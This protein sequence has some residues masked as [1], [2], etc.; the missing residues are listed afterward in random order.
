MKRY[1]FTLDLIDDNELITAYKQYHERI[2]PEISASIKS[3]GILD[4]EIYLFGNR[5]FMVMDVNEDFSF[6]R[7]AAADLEN[8]K[9]QEWETLMWNYQKALPQSKPGEKWLLMEQIFKL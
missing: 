6:E 2:W 1:C 3:A 8:A 5:L 7:K 9:V 4:M